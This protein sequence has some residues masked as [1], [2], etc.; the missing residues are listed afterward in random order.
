M[1]NIQQ[2]FLDITSYTIDNAKPVKKRVRYKTPSYIKKY[3]L[4]R[5]NE[6]TQEFFYDSDEKHIYRYKVLQNIHSLIYGYC[7]INPFEQFEIKEINGLI[8]HKEDMQAEIKDTWRLSI[9]ER[10]KLHIRLLRHLKQGNTIGECK[11]LK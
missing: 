9:G 11:W 3:Q 6:E 1:Q 2:C 8:C 5:F 7:G 4:R 10:L